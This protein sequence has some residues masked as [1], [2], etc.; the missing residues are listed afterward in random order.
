MISP[1]TLSLQ[2][3][4][5]VCLALVLALIYAT[6]DRESELVCKVDEL[7]DSVQELRSTGE[8]GTTKMLKMQKELDE[9]QWALK[10]A[11][12][13][14]LETENG[15]YYDSRG[16]ISLSDKYITA[17]QN[18]HRNFTVSKQPKFPQ[19]DARKVW[20]LSRCVAIYDIRPHSLHF[21]PSTPH[22]SFLAL[23]LLDCDETRAASYPRA[24][25]SSRLH[26]GGH[27]VPLGAWGA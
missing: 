8:Q 21:P 2:I 24:S 6:E 4:L 17:M 5:H 10:R 14:F 19:D 20:V 15:F 1:R 18:K 27:G 16:F 3:S 25:D 9:S 23:S 13:N 22:P 12:N 26:G 7:E 11:Q